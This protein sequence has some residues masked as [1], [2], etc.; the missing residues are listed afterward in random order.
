VDLQGQAADGEIKAAGKLDFEHTRPQMD[1]KVDANQLELDKLPKSWQLPPFGGR[2]N[3]HADLQVTLIDAKIQT[4]GS[5]QGKITGV[6]IPG[7]PE[8]KPIL[9][10]LYPFVE[11]FVSEKRRQPLGRRTEGDAGS[12][13]VAVK[14]REHLLARL[15]RGVS[16][17]HSFLG[18]RAV[19]LLRV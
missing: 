10:R 13:L 16:P 11:A 1:F 2:L 9:L 15:E 5:G 14:D 7:A 3:G 19:V 4:N 6:R 18:H 8:S 12:T 17:L